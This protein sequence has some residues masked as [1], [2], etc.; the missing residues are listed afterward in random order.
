MRNYLCIIGLAILLT[1]GLNACKGNNK[2]N[3]ADSVAA[4]ADSGSMNSMPDTART[5][6]SNMDSS[7]MD[8]AAKRPL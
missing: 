4:P 5:D 6:T 7:R 8:S 3:N 1:M 2:S